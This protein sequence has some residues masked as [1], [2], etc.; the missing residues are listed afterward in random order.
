L[1]SWI[2]SDST[3]SPGT[4]T[5]SLRLSPKSRL[6]S[7]SLKVTWRQLTIPPPVGSFE[8]L[9]LSVCFICRTFL[10]EGFFNAFIE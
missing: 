6:S 3:L 8:T 7:F 10:S 1:I 4:M 5:V 2:D 9:I